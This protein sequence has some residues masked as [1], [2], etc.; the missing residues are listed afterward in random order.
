MLIKQS[1]RRR[2]RNVPNYLQALQELVILVVIELE[3][4]IDVVIRS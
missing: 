4:K 3:K 2:I 1:L